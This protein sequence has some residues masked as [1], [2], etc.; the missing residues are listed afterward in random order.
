MRKIKID[1]FDLS[2][3]NAYNK[4]KYPFLLASTNNA[5]NTCSYNILFAYPQEEIILNNIEDYNFLAALDNCLTYNNKIDAELPFVGGYFV[6]L[7][8]EFIAQI[9]KK[10]QTC[11]KKYKKPIA[12]AA[13]VD[14]AIIVNNI[15]NATFIVDSG[16]N[17]SIIDEILNDIT[18]AKKIVKK[19]TNIDA[20]VINY[21]RN[22]FIKNVAIIKKYIKAG[23]VFQ[24]NLSRLWQLKLNKSYSANDIYQV[25]ANKNP[26][27]FAAL[28]SFCGIDI[29]CASPERLFK[30]SAG[31]IQTRPIAGTSPR[32]VA[33]Y[34][35]DLKKQ[36]LASP[37]EQAEHI[38]LLD[39]E[40][41]DMG[42]ICQYGSI[43]IDE[44]M[45]VESYPS[46]HHIVSNI[47][48][49]LKYNI[50]FGDIIKAIFP[51]GTITGCPK[52]RCMEIISELEDKPRGAYTG[53]IGYISRDGQMDFNIL[54]RSFIKDNDSLELRTGA[55]IVF[56]SN[57]NKEADET[58][59]KAKGML[60][61][62]K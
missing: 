34:D 56:D 29:I 28:A 19:I 31:N 50:S 23:D 5:K 8:Y 25:L 12:Y 61:I 35:I 24:V 43:K 38:M 45:I 27:P 58:Q 16:D 32:G 18:Q 2:L 15:T 48:G 40:R 21:D 57:P 47:S 3:L 42:K 51:G 30:V 7:S 26:A 39:L 9:E 17:K 13:K 33:D 59:H 36:L 44:F 49:K 6:Y 4:D 62:V 60:A 41:N 11:I 54:I 1:Y 46:V 14:V 22:I 37:K 10:L 20:S 52:I 53:A 55:G